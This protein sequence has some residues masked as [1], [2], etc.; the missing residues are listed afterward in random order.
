[1]CRDDNFE[2][3]Y[4]KSENVGPQHRLQ[5]A[6]NRKNPV[7]AGDYL[8]Y[9]FGNNEDIETQRASA[10]SIDQAHQELH[11]FR[12]QPRILP[13][14]VVR[15]TGGFYGF[16]RIV[17]DFKGINLQRQSEMLASLTN[18]CLS[19]NGLCIKHCDVLDDEQL[20]AL[21]AYS[22]NSLTE[23]EIHNNLSITEKTFDMLA[24]DFSALT[25]FIANNIGIQE[26]KRFA[27]RL[28]V[29]KHLKV[30][31]LNRCAQ[32]RQL[33]LRVDQLVYIEI[34][35][36]RSLENC[37]LKLNNLSDGRISK[38]PALK[39]L[40]IEI[41]KLDK[42]L[43]DG[44]RLDCKFELQDTA[45]LEKTDEQAKIKRSFDKALSQ[46]PKTPWLN[47]SFTQLFN[48]LLSPKNVD[49]VLKFAL[50][51]KRSGLLQQAI[52]HLLVVI[53]V[54]NSESTCY[55]QASEALAEIAKHSSLLFAFITQQLALQLIGDDYTSSVKA[56]DY[57]LRLADDHCL[58]NNVIKAIMSLLLGRESSFTKYGVGL[59]TKLAVNP[60]YATKIYKGLSSILKDNRH[61]VVMNAVACIQKIVDQPN[62]RV[63]EFI[64]KALFNSVTAAINVDDGYEIIKLLISVFVKAKQTISAND[65]SDCLFYIK[66]LD[67]CQQWIKQTAIHHSY[68]VYDDALNTINRLSIVFYHKL[69][70]NIYRLV[71]DKLG[72]YLET[73]INSP[74][75]VLAMLELMEIA[76]V[77]HCFAPICYTV[78]DYLSASG[79]YNQS[80]NKIRKLLHANISAYGYL[81][82]LLEQL[83]KLNRIP[84][85]AV[86]KCINILHAKNKPTWL[87]QH[88]LWLGFIGLLA[89]M[90]K[91]DFNIDLELQTCDAVNDDYAEL[92]AAFLDKVI[93]NHQPKYNKKAIN[94]IRSV[95]KIPCYFKWTVVRFNQYMQY[96]S[97][98]L[99]PTVR[100]LIELIR[101]DQQPSA[102]LVIDC[103]QY[104]IN[105]GE[106]VLD[107]KLV[108]DLFQGCPLDAI[109]QTNLD[110]EFKKSIIKN[111][112]YRYFIQKPTDY[113]CNES[114]QLIF[115]SYKKESTESISITGIINQQ[116][117]ELLQ[118]PDILLRINVVAFLEKLAYR[119][120]LSKE[121][122]D[123]LI[124]QLDTGDL[125]L[126]CAVIKVL[127]ISLKC[128]RPLKNAI[129]INLNKIAEKLLRLQKLF[130]ESY[131]PSMRTVAGLFTFDVLHK[132]VDSGFGEDSQESDVAREYIYKVTFVGE[133]FCGKTVLMKR[134]ETGLFSERYRVS[135]GVDFALKILEIGNII[136]KIQLWDISGQERFG[137][138]THVYY[139]DSALILACYACHDIYTYMRTFDG[140]KKWIY[141]ARVKTHLS[142]GEL[143]PIILVGTKLDLVK[144]SSD[145][146]VSQSEV[147]AY[148]KQEGIEHYIECSAKTGENIEELLITAAKVAAASDE[149][150]NLLE[151][152]LSELN[153]DILNQITYIMYPKIPLAALWAMQLLAP[154]LYTNKLLLK[155]IWYFAT[156]PHFYNNAQLLQS[157]GLFSSIFKPLTNSNANAN[158]N[159]NGDDNSNIDQGVLEGI[160]QKWE[161]WSLSIL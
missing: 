51:Y 145:R 156:R 126:L 90:G 149:R 34:N 143:V 28:F 105:R 135:I 122:L 73:E 83:N 30:L 103:L 141:D 39:Y 146:T 45:G 100:R 91:D 114:S 75:Y 47:R 130:K 104:I 60:W 98:Q 159:S 5:Q 63:P 36:N 40:K 80:K 87:E 142:S 92:Y 121:L 55:T 88:E 133:K 61:N 113:Y 137:S 23:L 70:I 106:E 102:M 43:I 18:G 77:S 11:C 59:L 22:H 153:I 69:R 31:M 52:D 2:K 66:A 8:H 139:K 50:E 85:R 118:T 129:K 20:S 131:L 26:I 132:M 58:S 49:I 62:K 37:E 10:I 116:L 112:L 57:L 97:L 152:K 71:Q 72:K 111:L 53:R 120:R 124:K 148:A 110:N 86:A 127:S 38:N 19:F 15:Y 14:V 42:M 101:K 115:N 65:N 95:C 6:I 144:S 82:N 123:M 84:L 125:G 27:N 138:M 9:Y 157:H 1:V 17:L 68:D 93:R 108:V 99:Y 79:D 33:L 150:F 158:A 41:D 44:L 160:D 154:E 54:T 151:L 155:R 16:S 24:E 117:I 161:Q 13:D 96:N 94:L 48:P 74:Q 81:I 35:S 76:K 12:Y 109:L 21:L 136:F 119:N 46:Q 25:V 56:G 140:V 29:F 107:R 32:L 64:I 134:M 7:T 89:S 147:L 4:Y 128:N 78:I 3:A 67:R